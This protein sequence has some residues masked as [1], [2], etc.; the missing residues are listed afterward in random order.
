MWITSEQHFKI[1][2]LQSTLQ[3]DKAYQATAKFCDRNYVI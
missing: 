2:M 1:I 3:T